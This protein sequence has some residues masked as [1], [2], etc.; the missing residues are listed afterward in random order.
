[1]VGLSCGTPSALAWPLL[2]PG[3]DATIAVPLFVAEDAMRALQADSAFFRI[4][5][6][7]DSI[8]CETK[9]RIGGRTISA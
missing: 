2:R 7:G 6:Q 5:G 3:L 1:M 9:R 4:V 8:G